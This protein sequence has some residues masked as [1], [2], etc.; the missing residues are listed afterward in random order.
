MSAS[1]LW[2]YGKGT[3]TGPLVMR[4][5]DEYGNDT[6]AFRLPGERALIIAWNFP[7]RRDVSVDV[8]PVIEVNR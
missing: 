3:W 7:L 8:T 1:R 5:G 2:F 6:L 4:G